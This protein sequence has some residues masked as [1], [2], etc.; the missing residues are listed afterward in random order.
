MLSSANGRRQRIVTI[1]QCYGSNEIHAVL[2]ASSTKE[3]LVLTSDMVVCMYPLLGLVHNLYY[4]F[5]NTF[6]GT[7]NVEIPLESTMA[8][9]LVPER[10]LG[11]PRCFAILMEGGAKLQSEWRLKICNGTNYQYTGQHG[12]ISSCWKSLP[13]TIASLEKSLLS[14]F[15]QITHD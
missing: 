6:R 14:G 5:S 1:I 3:A 11:D 2:K 10:W 13:S 9:E 7:L 4:D 8:K 15:G 12:L